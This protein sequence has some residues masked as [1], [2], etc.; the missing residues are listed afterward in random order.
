MDKKEIALCH[1]NGDTYSLPQRN[2]WIGQGAQVNEFRAKSLAGMLC[3]KPGDRGCEH[4][5]GAAIAY[6]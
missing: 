5:V 3:Q 2:G 6:E 1:F 4:S